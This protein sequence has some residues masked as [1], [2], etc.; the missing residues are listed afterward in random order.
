MGVGIADMRSNGEDAVVI[1]CSDLF[2]DS[3]GRS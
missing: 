2:I 3:P 1:M